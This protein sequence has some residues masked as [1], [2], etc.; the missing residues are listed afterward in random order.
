M[1]AYSSEMKLRIQ[2]VITFKLLI[3]L[4]VSCSPTQTDVSMTKKHTVILTFTDT[5]FLPLCL[6]KLAILL[7]YVDGDHSMDLC[8][9]SAVQ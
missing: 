7:L 9:L 8:E 1:Q 6:Y 2:G 3:L 4:K 5:S